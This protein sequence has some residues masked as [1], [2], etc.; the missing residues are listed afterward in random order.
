M[1]AQSLSGP[2][3]FATVTSIEYPDRFRVDADMPGG[4]LAQVYA[5]GRYWIEDARGVNEIPTEARALIQANVQR[6]AVRVLVKAATGKLVVREIDSDD[7]TL[8]AIEITGDGMSPLSLFI[9]RDTGLIE[10]AQYRSEPEGRA[11]ESY[12]DYRTVNG[13]KFAFHT[14]VR[15][16][17]LPPIERDVKTIRYNVLLPPGLFTKPS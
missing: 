14:V 4:K 3:P 6:D 13:V 10:K 5:D 8:G 2:I 12:S 9:N 16:G 11:E 17:G 15:R 7:P 1:T